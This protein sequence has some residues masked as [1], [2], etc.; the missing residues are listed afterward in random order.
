LALALPLSRFESRVA[1]GSFYVGRLTHAMTNTMPSFDY[2]IAGEDGFAAVQ[3]LW[4]NL[5][6][7]HSQLPWRFAGEMNRV[8]FEPRKQEILTK[9]AP[10]KLRI[11]LVSTA[12][13]MRL[14]PW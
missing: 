10:G 3:P 9:G 8:T 5:R 7:Y 12:S 13:V 11:E 1:G 6:A 2:R 14:P 4:L